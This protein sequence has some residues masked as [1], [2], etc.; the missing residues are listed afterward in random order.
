MEFIRLGIG[1][2]ILDKISEGYTYHEIQKL[3]GV[4]ATAIW[5]IT[6]KNKTLC[7]S[8]FVVARIKK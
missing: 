7:P 6:K 4:P 5:R 1:K 3:Y 2:F 8:G